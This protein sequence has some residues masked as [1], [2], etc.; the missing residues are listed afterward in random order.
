MS[1]DYDRMLEGYDQVEEA[2]TME[3][4]ALPTGWYPLEIAQV[5]AKAVSKNSV[6][7]VRVR[8]QVFE[9]EHKGRSAFLMVNLGASGVRRDKA[10]NE[11]ERTPQEVQ[12]ATQNV[13]AQAKRFMRSIGVNTGRPSGE[14]A[15]KVFN[16]YNVDSW[17]GTQLMGR[18]RYQEGRP[19]PAGGTYGPSNNLSTYAPLDDK[20]YGIEAYRAKNGAASSSKKEAVR[21]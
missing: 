9:G 5:M 11:F 19:N 8:A 18:L 1:V 20:K 17:E 2:A 12:E 21:L 6:P 13:Q 16:F 10:G 3:D 4:G 15:D 14:G 7:Y